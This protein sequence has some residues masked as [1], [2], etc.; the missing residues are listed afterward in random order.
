MEIVWKG[1]EPLSQEKK[2]LINVPDTLLQEVDAV[3][4]DEKVSRSR[5]ITK[6]VGQ[7]V[8]KKKNTGL[9]QQMKIGYKEMA[10]IN[11]RLAEIYF[12]ADCQQAESFV[13]NLAESE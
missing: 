1:A 6:A 10:D 11:L 7:Y 12:P 8:G 3:A 4:R 13:E 9:K 2:I 5:L